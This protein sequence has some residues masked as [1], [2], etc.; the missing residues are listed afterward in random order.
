MVERT[1]TVSVDLNG[2]TERIRVSSREVN[3]GAVRQSHSLEES[4]RA[5]QGIEESIRN[6]FV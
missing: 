4:Y 6:N 1:R 2:A 3:D 5:M